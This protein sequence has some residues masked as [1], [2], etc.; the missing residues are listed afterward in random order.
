MTHEHFPEAYSDACSGY[1]ALRPPN[2]MSISEGAAAHLVIKQTGGSA[3]PW[4]PTETP[5][6]VEPMNALA[7]RKHEAVVMAK[8]ARTGGTADSWSRYCEGRLRPGWRVDLGR[9]EQSD[10]LRARD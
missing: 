4:S 5:Y 2:R 7:S 1:E 3:A 10:R 8:P 6:M 9:C